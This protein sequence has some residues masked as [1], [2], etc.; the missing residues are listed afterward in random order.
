VGRNEAHRL[1]C[2]ES[3]NKRNVTVRRVSVFIVAMAVFDVNRGPQNSKF[4]TISTRR[5]CHRALSPTL[6]LAWVLPWKCNGLGVEY[7]HRKIMLSPHDHVRVKLRVQ[8]SDSF[9]D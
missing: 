8:E 1:P 2:D 5:P 4:R 6:I 9:E 3:S 7:L